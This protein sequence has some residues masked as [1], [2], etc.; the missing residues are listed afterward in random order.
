MCIQ[1]VSRHKKKL[2][3]LCV[4]EWP[5]LGSIGPKKGFNLPITMAVKSKILGL[6]SGP[7]SH[8]DQVPYIIVWKEL[9]T[10]PLLESVLFSLAGFFQ[11]SI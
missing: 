11:D 6:G 10:N 9:I 1:L 3:T 5:V 4:S 8:P 7:T 2:Q